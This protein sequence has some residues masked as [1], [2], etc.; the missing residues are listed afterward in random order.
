MK[1]IK[2]VVSARKVYFSSDWHLDHVKVIGYDNR[3]FRDIG[4]MNKTIIDNFSE[5]DENDH[6]FFV[7]DLSFAKDPMR[8]VEMIKP[9]R[10]KL[11]WI[12]GNHDGHLLDCEELTSRFEWIQHL[13]EIT[14]IEEEHNKPSVRQD[15]TLCHYSMEV[16]NKSHHGAYHL[17]GHSH[18]SLPETMTRRSFDVGC[19]MWEYKP[20]SYR[21]I[22]EKM[23]THTYVPIDHHNKDT[24]EGTLV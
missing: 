7:G 24:S 11:Y 21:Q 10:C 20:I 4:H 15:I 16:W 18:G 2:T 1:I 13:A 22:K 6:L 17:Y 9:L 12:P 19:N 5:L 23:R 14:V 3:P 8:V